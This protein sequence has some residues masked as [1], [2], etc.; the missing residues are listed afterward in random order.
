MTQVL[1]ACRDALFTPLCPSRHTPHLEP[2]DLAVPGVPCQSRLVCLFCVEE[3]SVASYASRVRVL[4][5]VAAASFR[6][7]LTDV[8]SWKQCRTER[9]R[10]HQQPGRSC[11]AFN[12]VQGIT[13]YRL[14]N[15]I[16]D[17]VALG[18]CRHAGATTKQHGLLPRCGAQSAGGGGSSLVWVCGWYHEPHQ[19]RGGAPLPP[20]VFC[21]V[22]LRPGLGRMSS[23]WRKANLFCTPCEPAVLRTWEGRC[24]FIVAKMLWRRRCQSY[25]ICG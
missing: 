20:C 6:R 13:V 3:V 25:C 15:V 22:T 14:G 1:V 8:M 10:L 21:G 5:N 19:P 11:F 7:S 18:H 23:S 16:S 2:Q 4:Q 9:P 24:N 17:A 12:T